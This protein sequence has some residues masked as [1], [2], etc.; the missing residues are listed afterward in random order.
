MFIG[1]VHDPEIAS[2][3]MHCSSDIINLIV[4]VQW[5]FAEIEGILEPVAIR[6]SGSHQATAIVGLIIMI[7]TAFGRCAVSDDK[8]VVLINGDGRHGR[9]TLGAV[10]IETKVPVCGIDVTVV[11]LV[12]DDEIEVLIAI[13]FSQ[14]FESA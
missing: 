3:A 13:G 14:G 7:D 10:L 9:G 4:F 11:V 5:A 6:I 12:G 2:I 1:A 8:V